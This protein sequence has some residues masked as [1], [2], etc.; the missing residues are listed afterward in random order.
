MGFKITLDG[1]FTGEHMGLVFTQGTA[2]TEDAFLASR[3][4]SKGYTVTADEGV[5]GEAVH[6]SGEVTEA[7]AAAEAGE[8]PLEEMTVPLL[9]E[10]AAK[11]GIDLGG[12]RN[13]SEI[14]SAIYAAEAAKSE[15]EQ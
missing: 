6:D 11:N 2:H 8:I 10:H 12:A 15:T 1:N 9:K 5:S 4:Q 14:I 3:L 7:H 13:K